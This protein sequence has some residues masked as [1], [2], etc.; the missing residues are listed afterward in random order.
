MKKVVLAGLAMG[1]VVGANADDLYINTSLK[2][3]SHKVEIEK[4]PVYDMNGVID[5]NKTQG[6]GHDKKTVNSLE[7]TLESIAIDEMVRKATHHYV[8]G[9]NAS[10]E[11]GS[12]LKSIDISGYKQVVSEDNYNLFLTHGFKYF[13]V[14]DYDALAPFL[15]FKG[16]FALPFEHSKIYYQASYAI[17]GLGQ[18]IKSV[19]EAEAGI[20]INVPKIG[21]VMSLG[22][23]IKQFDNKKS[24]VDSKFLRLGYSKTF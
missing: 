6:G 19:L 21:G 14:N 18:E 3:Y 17:G 4:S 24:D 23:G 20:N 1:I 10:V 9:L 7:I 22:A 16:D 2:H 13:N 12:F 15:G 11:V 8:D 5:P